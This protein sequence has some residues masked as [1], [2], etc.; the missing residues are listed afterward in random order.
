MNWYLLLMLFRIMEKR[1]AAFTP[2]H[3]REGKLGAGFADE[4]EVG[5]AGLEI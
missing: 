4:S 5:H 3:V 2:A 1:F